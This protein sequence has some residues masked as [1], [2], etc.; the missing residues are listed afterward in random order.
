MPARHLRHLLDDLEDPF[1]LFPVEE[2]AGDL[3]HCVED[4]ENSRYER[5]DS[6]SSVSPKYYADQDVHEIRVIQ[7][8]TGSVFVLAQ[9]AIMQT[10]SIMKRIHELAAEPAWLPSEKFEIMNTAAPIHE[11]SGLSKIAIIDAAANYVKHHYEWPENWVDAKTKTQR[12]TI[13]IITT[14][15]LEPD[16]FH[17][18]E[19]AMQRLG[20]GADKMKS[21]PSMLQGWREGL[22]SHVRSQLA[23]HG[24][25]Y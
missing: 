24:T 17:N 25:Q 6:Y 5:L 10:V 18:L 14:I 23:K 4:A 8:L 2:V 21:L 9:A 15:G 12:S 13:D 3:A 19:T 22:A 7:L 20:F 16:G 1:E 11:T